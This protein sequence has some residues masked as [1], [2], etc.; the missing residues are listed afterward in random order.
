MSDQKR[1]HAVL[2]NARI[3]PRKAGLCC[4]LIRG[5]RVADA[6]NILAFD[7]RRGSAIMKKVLDSA[8][9]NAVNLGGVDPMDLVV[10]DAR[11]DKGMVLKRW[12]PASRGRTAAR[13]RRNSH[14]TIGVAVQPAA[15]KG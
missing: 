5:K 13:W 8:V 12:R 6:V 9:A 4:Q 1:F 2:R 7:L 10:V 14:I 11:V 15:R 3:S